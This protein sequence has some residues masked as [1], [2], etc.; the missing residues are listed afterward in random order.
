[1]AKN[2]QVKTIC[3]LLSRRRHHYI[4]TVVRMFYSS[5]RNVVLS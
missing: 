2:G 4:I 3:H 5:S 1:M